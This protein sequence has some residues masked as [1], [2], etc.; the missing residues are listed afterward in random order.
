MPNVYAYRLKPSNNNQVKNLL[1][2]GQIAIGWSHARVVDDTLTKEDVRREISRRYPRIEAEGKL[3]KDTNQVW[4]FLRELQIGDIVIVPDGDDVHFLRVIGH[5]VFLEDKIEKEDTAIRRDVV[6]V[7]PTPVNRSDLPAAIRNKLNFRGLASVKLDP[8]KDEVL[9]FLSLDGEV[10]AAEEQAEERARLLLEAIGS[11]RV[12]ARDEK[13]I[14]RK[15]AEVL[16]ALVELLKSQ[17]VKVANERNSGLAPDL[18]TV[19][20]DKPSL[21]EIKIAAG[22]GDYLKAVGQL[23]VYERLLKR[24]YQKFLVVPPGIQDFAARILKQLGIGIVEYTEIGERFIFHWGATESGD[25]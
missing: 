24:S 25:L 9:A 17:G 3:T 16:R 1:D 8:V 11:Y 4:R 5:P 23:L 2:D 20:D 6:R 18:F 15:H 13:L 19:G 12:S 22:A 21:F 10:A 14:A 7:I